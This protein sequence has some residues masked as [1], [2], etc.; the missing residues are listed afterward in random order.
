MSA[1]AG[2]SITSK[3]TLLIQNASPSWRRE[4]AR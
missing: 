4:K 3:P 1:N 2:M